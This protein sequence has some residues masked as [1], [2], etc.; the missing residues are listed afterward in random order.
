MNNAGDEAITPDNSFIIGFR[1][2]DISLFDANDEDN[3]VTMVASSKGG[4]CGTS[5]D[6]YD[7]IIIEDRRTCPDV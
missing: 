1:D 2:D 5:H 7:Q 6:G 3:G 4:Q